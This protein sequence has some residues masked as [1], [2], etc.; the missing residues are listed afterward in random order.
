MSTLYNIHN[1]LQTFVTT[2]ETWAS[3]HPAFAIFIGG[4]V[5]GLII[6]LIF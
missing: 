2:S 1:K 4:F 5:V 6:G 3:S